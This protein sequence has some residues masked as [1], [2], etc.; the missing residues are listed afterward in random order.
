MQ[1]DIDVHIEVD[2]PEKELERLGELL[3][4]GNTLSNAE[5]PIQFYLTTNLK[6]IARGDNAYDLLEDK[7]IKKSSKEDAQ[8]PISQILEIAKFFIAGIQ[9]RLG[10]YRRDKKELEIYKT[11]STEK[12]ELS[13]KDIEK[14]LSDK[15]NEIKAD[16]DAL[17]I[18]YHVIKGLRKE[19]FEKEEDIDFLVEIKIKKPNYSV[20]NLVYKTL[21]R[22]GYLEELREALKDREEFTK[23]T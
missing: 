14:L 18:G 1:R 3:P 2:F 7:W 9:D 16:L 11:Y 4:N 19:I 13:E 5:H 10:E 22:F 15:K 12:E 23:S 20:S 17:Y 21:E 6:D 8:V